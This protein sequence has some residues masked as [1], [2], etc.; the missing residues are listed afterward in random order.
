M[1]FSTNAAKKALAFF[2]TMLGLTI[3]SYGISFCGT[4]T[5]TITNTNDPSCYVGQIATGWYEYEAPDI[6]GTFD[7]NFWGVGH[8][9]ETPALCGSIFSFVQQFADG[10][11]WLPLAGTISRFAQLTVAGG[12]VSNFHFFTEYYHSS[13]H[14]E[15]PGFY[16]I[17]DYTDRIADKTFYYE[18]NGTLSFSAPAVK[19]P[20]G[21]STVGLLLLSLGGLSLFRRRLAA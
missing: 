11:G 16:A 10:D 15:F 20:D 7:A 18:T 14:F 19:V 12:N 1:K 5:Q 3:S 8:Q 6:D 21:A 2:I 13:V 9:G 4:I 17:T